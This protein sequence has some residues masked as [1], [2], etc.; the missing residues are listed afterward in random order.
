MAVEKYE[1][2]CFDC[3]KTLKYEH[4]YKKAY[5]GGMTEQQFNHIW[6]SKYVEFYCCSCYNIHMYRNIDTNYYRDYFYREYEGILH[7]QCIIASVRVPANNIFYCT[8]IY[9]T[10]N[11]PILICV[12][13]RITMGLFY[14]VDVSHGNILI[15]SNTAPIF[16][17]ENRTEDNVYIDMI[18]LDATPQH[19]IMG[20]IGGFI[21]PIE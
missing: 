13:D 2:V 21:I 14:Y 7:D 20:T 8:R 9:A 15:R 18:A 1:H 3:K 19:Y 6:R 5:E 17:N 11:I 16:R 10:S 12:K 4:V